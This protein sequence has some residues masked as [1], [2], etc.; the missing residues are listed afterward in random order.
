MAMTQLPPAQRDAIELAY[1]QGLTQREIS[2]RLGEP[3][4]TIKTRMRLGIQ[5]LREQLGDQ[6]GDLFARTEVEEA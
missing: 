4:G 3:L 6:L 2:E 1:F 5:K